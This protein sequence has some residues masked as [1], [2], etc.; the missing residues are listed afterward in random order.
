MSLMELEFA[1]KSRL[2]ARPDQF[3]IIKDRIEADAEIKSAA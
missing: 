3:A 2:R 1:E